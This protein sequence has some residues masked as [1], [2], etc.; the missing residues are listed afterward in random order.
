M[1]LKKVSIKTIISN[2]DPLNSFTLY[3][4]E[5][6]NKILI[7]IALTEGSAHAII[8]AQNK[9][10]TP[11][12][13]IHNTLKRLILGLGAKLTGAIIYKEHEGIYYTYLRL[14]NKK[15]VLD[16][17]AKATDALCVATRMNKPIFIYSNVLDKVGIKVTKELLDAATNTV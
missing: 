8:D 7:P 3:L 6:K 5:K 1:E 14:E 4:F 16:I 13:H 2:N 10:E 9:I 11:R 12:P 17:D 15:Q